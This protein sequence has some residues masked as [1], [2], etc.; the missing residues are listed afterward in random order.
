MEFFRS[1]GKILVFRCGDKIFELVC[2]QNDSFLSIR[3]CYFNLIFSYWISFDMANIMMLE[4]KNFHS[5]II[6]LVAVWAFCQ[7]LRRNS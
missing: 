6:I 2:V 3:K 4:V 5:D 1:F 7:V